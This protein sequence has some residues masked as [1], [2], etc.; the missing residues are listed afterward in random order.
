MKII[1]FKGVSGTG[2]TT[3]IEAV[4][5]ELRNRGYS[6]GTVKDIHS[7]SFTMDT[8]GK[9]TFRHKCA[10]AE[11]VTARGK[12]ETDIMHYRQLDI[13]EILDYYKT[14][15]VILEGDSG[16]NCPVILTAGETEELDERMSDLVI[17]VTGIISGKID[18]Y[19][20]LPVINGLTETQRLVDLIEEKTPERS[21]CILGRNCVKLTVGKEEIQMP[22]SV[23]STLADAV[24]S[25]IKDLK[26]FK[27][28]AE[29][30]VRI[31]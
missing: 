21:H 25:V 10:G 18:E 24:F 9:N 3:T 15:Y 27:N 26:G 17:A 11:I 6:V 23:Q 7:N 16:A 5:Q 2:K 19:R 13:D 4:I 28:D 20:A 22:P 12:K 1:M 29:I 31:K 8:E 30:V 14:D